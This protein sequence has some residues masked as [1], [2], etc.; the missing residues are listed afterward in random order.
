MNY[1]TSSSKAG[2]VPLHR[3]ALVMLLEAYNE[4][5]IKDLAQRIVK[6][7]GE[8]STLQLRGR[9]DFEA[10][11][12]AYEY[13]ISAADFPYRH[14]SD[15]DIFTNRQSL[16]VQHD[17]GRKYSYF[18]AEGF[19]AYFEAVTTKKVEYS[20]TDNCVVLTID[21]GA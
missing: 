7:T 16:I 2:L 14:E 8:D 17:M 20:I 12:Y 13:W 11:L 5:Q 1:G 9:Y 3:L 19:K 18:V 10:A 6:I 15:I 21:G 4:E